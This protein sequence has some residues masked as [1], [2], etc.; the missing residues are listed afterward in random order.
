MTT[1]ANFNNVSHGLPKNLTNLLKKAPK[2]REI[3]PISSQEAESKLKTDGPSPAKKLK[4]S[5][6]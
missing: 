6:T 1:I 2:I 5:S 4:I 3:V